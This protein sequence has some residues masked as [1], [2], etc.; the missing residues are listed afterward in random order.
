MH[1]CIEVKVDHSVR[2]AFTRERHKESNRFSELMA[3]NYS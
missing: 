2:R 3:K 1:L